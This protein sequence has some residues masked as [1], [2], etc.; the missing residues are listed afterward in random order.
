[1][2]G[3]RVRDEDDLKSIW[4]FVFSGVKSVFAEFFR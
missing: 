1:M 3:V 2:R 4:I